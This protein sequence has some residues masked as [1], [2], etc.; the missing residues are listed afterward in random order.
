MAE[1]LLPITQTAEQK[2]CPGCRTNK[3][4]NQFG[5]QTKRGK[6]TTRSRCRSCE[7]A[8]TAA[9]R[10]ADPDKAKR[11]YQESARR[12]REARLERDRAWN[13]ANPE[14]R[15][16]IVRRSR[17][18]H[19]EKVRA[20][21]RDRTRRY[22]QDPIVRLRCG[23]SNYVRACV[24]GNK[25]GRS[26]TKVLGYDVDDLRAHLERQFLKGMSWEN[27]GEWHID[28]IVPVS[29]FNI[30][31]VDC[32]ELRRAWALTNLRPLWAKDNLRKGAK[33]ETLL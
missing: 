23:V 31:G 13:K 28:H 22:R 2:T 27:M 29:S 18:K 33:V 26:W 10:A 11:S 8:S 14:R 12:T 25:E 19:K 7:A 24:R 3:D 21:A 32:P 15:A 17:Q 30:T 16:E 20:S 1:Q 6:V 9:W 5:I 4:I